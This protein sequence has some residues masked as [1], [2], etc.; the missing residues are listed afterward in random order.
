MPKKR[1]KYSLPSQFLE[2]INSGKEIHGFW[3]HEIVREARKA[4]GL[5]MQELAKKVGCSQGFLSRFENGDKSPTPHLLEKILQT[6]D[7]RPDVLFGEEVIPL[8]ASDKVKK[9]AEKE[10]A[11]RK[12]RQAEWKIVARLA[13][14]RMI[15]AVILT[16]LRKGGYEAE[17]RMPTSLSGDPECL[18]IEVGKDDGRR[19]VLT[20][21][22]KL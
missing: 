7:L 14:A 16:A 5:T 1:A 13:S 11:L 10:A 6:L 4:K 3:Q 2:Q 15:S 8:G 20:I 21:R 12:V 17:A 22:E 19:F 18:E 9:R